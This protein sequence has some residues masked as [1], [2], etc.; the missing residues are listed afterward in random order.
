MCTQIKL[1][2]S[3][4]LNPCS[5]LK[6]SMIFLLKYKFTKCNTYKKNNKYIKFQG[7]ISV[8]FP[9]QKAL[10]LYKIIYKS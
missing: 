2:I 9:I 3:E 4:N 8:Y 6:L 1:I 10:R 7:K 5:M